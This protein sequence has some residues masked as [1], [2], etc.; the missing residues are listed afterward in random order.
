[1]HQEDTTPDGTPGIVADI[2]AVRVENDDWYT[3]HLCNQSKARIVAAAAYVETLIRCM[4]ATSADDEILDVGVTDDVASTLQT[5]GY[6]RTMISHHTKPEIQ[7]MDAA[8]AGRCLPYDPG[9]ITWNLKTL[10][11]V[12]YVDYTDTEK[13]VLKAKDCNYYTRIAGVSVTQIGITPGHEWFDVINGIDWT[14]VRMQERIFARLAAAKKVPFTD[15]GIAVPENEVRGVLTEGVTKEIYTSD[16]AP[17]VTA[18]LAKNV[19]A[20]DKAARTLTGLTFSAT[21]AGAIHEV[22]VTGTVSV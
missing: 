17:T 20:A 9:S 16:P 10:T 8:W 2:A 13:A 14:Q 15:R 7:H 6:V 1:M 11:G 5:A 12:D 21:L 3:V 19:S 22:E 18:P 4:V